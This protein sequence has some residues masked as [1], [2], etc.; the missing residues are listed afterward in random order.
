M[1][2]FKH[3]I[4]IMCL[5]VAGVFSATAQTDDSFDEFR[6][7][8]LKDYKSFRNSVLED[9]D[10][11]LSGIWSEYKA[12]KGEKRDNKPK[13]PIA[14]TVDNLKPLPEIDSSISNEK[15][16]LPSPPPP[17]PKN[18]PVKSPNT[19]LDQFDFYGI[20]L[21]LPQLGIDSNDNVYSALNYAELWRYYSS[22]DI[23]KAFIPA[24][25]SLITDKKFNDWFAFDL[26]RKYAEKCYG[27]SS[28]KMRIT[29]EHFLLTNL[30]YNIRLAETDEKEPLLLV[31]T[32]HTIYSRSFLNID[33]DIYYIFTDKDSRINTESGFSMYT[34]DI[35]KSADCGKSINMIISEEMNIPFNPHPYL[36][37]YNGLAIKG[38]VN[39]NLMPMLYHYPQVPLECYEK[40][41]ISNTLRQSI[42]SQ[43]KSGI[44]SQNSNSS[45]NELLHFV[46]FAFKYATDEEQHGFEKPYFLEEILYYP[47][48][49]CE[50]RSIFFSYILSNVLNIENQIITY[51]GHAA[52]AVK[53][54]E[55]IVGDS[56]DFDG[57]TFYISDPTYIGSN[58][59]ICMPTYKAIRPTIEYHF[60]PT[61]NL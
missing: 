33:G 55:K 47:K 59:G 53:L 36:W 20:T 8:L 38:E 54:D 41:V 4:V 26:V 6:N 46:Q 37:E 27:S 56:Y 9:Y 30:G 3:H 24:L 17:T 61:N 48:C 52:V 35:P 32:S 16:Q 23:T 42:I 58:T 31:S 2:D 19:N 15:P 18:E 21:Q 60:K 57:T 25:K 22:Q 39:A 40:S 44:T 13:P 10:K 29:L 14:P 51:P 43:L 7:S 45:V 34:C 11:F 28:I 1:K 49:D 50:D 5:A 12:F